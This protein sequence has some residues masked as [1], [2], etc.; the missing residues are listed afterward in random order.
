MSIQ[1]NVKGQRKAEQK[2]RSDQA[3]AKRSCSH[4]NRVFNNDGASN[5][6]FASELTDNQDYCPDCGS[7]WY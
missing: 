4:V 2:K 6:Y 1:A 5:Y 7:I 3:K